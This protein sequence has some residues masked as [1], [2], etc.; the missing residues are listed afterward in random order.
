MAVTCWP[1]TLCTGDT[2]AC[3]E[4]SEVHE[5]SWKKQSP[6]I[7]PMSQ[8]SG[9]IQGQRMVEFFFSLF[10]G[11]VNIFFYEGP[12]KIYIILT[13]VHQLYRIF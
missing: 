10:I 13:Y 5:G 9:G 3:G 6:R 1:E 8:A 7:T 12:K 4:E 11:K 2:G